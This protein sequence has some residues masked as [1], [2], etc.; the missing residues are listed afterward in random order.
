MA[1]NKKANKEKK[2]RKGVAK[3]DKKLKTIGANAVVADIVAAALVATAAALKDSKRAR[4]LASEAGEE[5]AKLS[6]AGA[7]R[8]NALW[9]MALQI[10]RR[11]LDA[12]TAGKT[13]KAS[14]PKSSSRGAAKKG[15]AAPKSR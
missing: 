10:S 5:L 15:G 3:A 12:M 9:D 6:K 8:G 11:S 13:S 1:K 4:A 14:E 7:E 2:Q